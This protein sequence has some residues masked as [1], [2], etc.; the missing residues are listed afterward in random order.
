MRAP[1]DHTTEEHHIYELNKQIEETEKNCEQWKQQ[2][3][4][5]WGRKMQLKKQLDRAIE[6]LETIFQDNSPH[7]TLE[8]VVKFAGETLSAINTQVKTK[9]DR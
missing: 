3:I 6:A 1:D 2:Y 5:E 8:S 9:G 7:S 4:T